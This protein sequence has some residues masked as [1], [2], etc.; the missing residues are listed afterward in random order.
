MKQEQGSIE[1]SFLKVVDALLALD[2]VSDQELSKAL[3]EFPPERL[4]GIEGEM[5]K[6]LSAIEAK[7]KGATSDSIFD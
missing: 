6:L 2:K 1:T 7:R 5:E 4:E 3:A